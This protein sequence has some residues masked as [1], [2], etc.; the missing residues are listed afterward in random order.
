MRTYIY[1]IHIKIQEG[2]WVTALR[3]LV[4][5]LVMILLFFFF[6]FLFLVLVFFEKSVENRI[7]IV[8]NCGWFSWRFCSLKVSVW[9]CVCVRV[10]FVV[11]QVENLKFFVAYF[12]A[13]QVIMS[14]HVYFKFTAY[15]QAYSKEKNPFWKMFFS[16][17]SYFCATCSLDS[18]KYFQCQQQLY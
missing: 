3:R 1:S 13:A 4:S 17:C 10:S 15:L 6:F 18:Y 9:V 16:V 14:M 11:S 12:C 5:D 7:L 8:L 2:P